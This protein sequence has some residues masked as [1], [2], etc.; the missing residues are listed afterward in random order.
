M[1]PIY[2]KRCRLAHAAG[3]APRGAS[4]AAHLRHDCQPPT[5]PNHPL[6]SAR[7]TL[8]AAAIFH[9]GG[10]PSLPPTSTSTSTSTITPAAGERARA[11][12]AGRVAGRRG[13]PPGALPLLARRYKS[14]HR[15]NSGA[16]FRCVAP[17][18]R[19]Q[20]RRGHLPTGNSHTCF[21][22]RD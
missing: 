1:D 11:R 18:S 9:G 6:S 4:P 19:V 12:P 17:A 16:H 7:R 20:Q 10:A 2:L 13:P 22:G 15:R 14:A 8:G 21:G 5:T 3:P